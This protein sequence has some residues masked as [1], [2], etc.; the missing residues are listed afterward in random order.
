[1]N[2]ERSLSKKSCCHHRVKKSE[3]KE[4]DGKDDKSGKTVIDRIKSVIHK[5]GDEA[6]SYQRL[7]EGTSSIS[8]EFTDVTKPSLS[9]PEEKAE[10]IQMK[11]LHDR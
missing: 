10:E 7:E 8:M 11:T 2:S 9:E 4:K 6:L 5:D 3:T 1:M